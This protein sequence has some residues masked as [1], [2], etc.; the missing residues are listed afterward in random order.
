MPTTTRKVTANVNNLTSHRVLL[1]EDDPADQKL[2]KASLK[3]VRSVIE[4]SVAGSAE[5]ALD[6]LQSAEANAVRPNLI[7][8]DINMPG[9][10]G[11]EF[12]KRL[13]ADE[14]LK[15]IPVV[16]VS[17]SK[18]DKDICDSYGLQA[19]GYVPKPPSMDELKQVMRRI[20]DYWFGTC[21]MA[22]ERR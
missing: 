16:V 11:K 12:L 14:T 8:L 21:V 15:R 20:E 18:A 13:K 9:M 3:E 2:L 1:V 5:Q 10:G 4:L 17:S 6:L 7:L 22:R 19:A